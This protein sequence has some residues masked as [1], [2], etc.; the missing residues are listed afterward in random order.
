MTDA[1]FTLWRY[2]AECG[3]YFICKHLADGDNGV[4]EASHSK[5]VFRW[6]YIL[7]PWPWI[8]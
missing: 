6:L 2:A 4:L 3:W 5:A 1:G 8:A 7:P